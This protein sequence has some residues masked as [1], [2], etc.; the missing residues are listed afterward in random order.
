MIKGRSLY[1]KDPDGDLKKCITSI[2]V[3]PILQE[4]YDGA[5]GGHL[6]V[7]SPSQGYASTFGGL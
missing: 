4:Y 3:K 7:I 2:N 1:Y 6:D 5:I